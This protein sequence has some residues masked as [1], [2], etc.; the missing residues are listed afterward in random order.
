MQ[1]IGSTTVGTAKVLRV[2]VSTNLGH[3]RLN[4]CQL[5]VDPCVKVLAALLNR[6][7]ADVEVELER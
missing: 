2:A 5:L 7:V 4:L 6:K 3:L 1:H